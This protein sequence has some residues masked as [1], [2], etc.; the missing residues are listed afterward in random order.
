MV[1]VPEAGT[2]RKRSK[3]R[4]WIV[5]IV[6]AAALI[7]VL[8]WIWFAV[9]VARGLGFLG[10]SGPGIT[11]SEQTTRITEPVGDDGYVDYLG[12]LNGRSREGV[13]PE[14][15]A[16]VLLWQAI[17]PAEAVSTCGEEGCDWLFR[18][19]GIPR[20]PVEGE[21]FVS[22]LEYGNQK[23]AA[24]P[25]P[26]EEDSGDLVSAIKRQDRRDWHRILRDQ[27]DQARK[28][29]W[30]KEEFPELAAWLERNDKPLE[31]VVAA[32]QRERFYA[33]L[34][35]PTQPPPVINAL[36]PGYPLWRKAWAALA[37]RAMLRLDEGKTKEAWQDLLAC[38][39]LAR[40]VGQSPTLV[41]GLVAVAVDAIACWGDAAAAQHGNLT[42]EQARR[43]RADLQALA[44]LPNMVD[45]FDVAERFMV[46]DTVTSM[47]R[48]GLAALDGLTDS[49]DWESAVEGQVSRRTG[50]L[51]LDWDAM[52]RMV[53]THY[54]QLV[55]AGRDA[56]R[57]KRAE[58]L[59]EFDEAMEEECK[60]SLQLRSLAKSLL[61]EG[62]RKM[63][64]ENTVKIMLALMIPP[65]S[66]SLQAEDRAVMTFQLTEVALALA[67][68]R[69]DHGRYPERLEQ[70][71]PEYLDT[72]P[73]DLFTGD[74]LRYQTS[75][76]DYLCYS[77]GFNRQDDEGRTYDSE[78]SGDDIVIRTTPPEARDE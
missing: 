5:G 69:V 36:M 53:N 67:G 71:V 23:Q 75:G 37:M 45:K 35:P 64:S 1:N 59:N 50:S 65:L 51:M 32:S 7:W 14:N 78:P 56:D 28:R 72:V 8:P 46:L 10:E 55:E 9:R 18:E 12:A 22:L 25:P 44:P 40:L 4:L 15:N 34:V 73:P 49:G 24:G 29:P 11:I 38:H 20:P 74:A 33:P 43:F 16:A 26:Q 47:A 66:A 30:S 57:P 48:D 39:R 54:D 76:Q 41:E 27:E 42:A 17:G 2:A 63:A 70:L 21:Y 58:A 13:T 52:L 3:R 68:Y 19:L 77:A 61:T 6:L 31:R 62:P 60:R